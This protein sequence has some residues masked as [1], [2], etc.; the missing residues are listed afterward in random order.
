MID[1]GGGGRSRA[2]IGNHHL[3]PAVGL[4]RQRRQHRL[5]RIRAIV[6]GHDERDETRHPQLSSIY[7]FV[8]GL[9][10]AKPGGKHPKPTAVR[11]ASSMPRRL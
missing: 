1:Q 7:N 6:S 5:E 8:P 3:E 2:I 4:A 9:D 10:F 11:D